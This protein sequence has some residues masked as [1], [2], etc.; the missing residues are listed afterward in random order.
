MHRL[1]QA[2]EP[3]FPAADIQRGLEPPRR[4]PF[5]HDRVEHMLAPPV[6]SL[7]HCRDPWAGRVVPAIAH[8][9]LQSNRLTL[10]SRK[11]WVEDERCKCTKE[12]DRNSAGDFSKWHIT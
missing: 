12:A 6:A 2:A 8:E 5:Q 11:G 4:D 9:V 10:H 1:Q 3:S 7:T